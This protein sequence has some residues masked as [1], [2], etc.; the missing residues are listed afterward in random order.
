MARRRAFVLLIGNKERG[1]I[2]HFQ[3]LQEETAAS[4]GRRLGIDVEV[5]F[6]PG[7]DQLR[8]L[9]KRL[10]DSA[11][12]PLDAVLTEPA[13]T[14]TMDLVLREL[15]GKV[16]LVILSAWGPSVE[17]AAPEW[18]AG[19]PLGTVG[20]DHVRVGEIQGRQVKA[21]LPSGGRVLCVAGPLRS[22]A[23]QQRLEGLKSQVGPGIELQ[24]ISA[25][26]WTES[27]GIVAFND[28]Y[29][30]AKAR[31]PIVQVVAAGNDELA[32]GARR[33]CEALASVEHRGALLKAR[34]IGVDACPTFGQRLVAENQIAASVFTPANTGLALSHLHRFWT[35]GTTVPLRSFTEARP[36]PP[37][38]AGA[39]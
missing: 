27:D 34:F 3:L 33:A 12:A 37:G 23:A 28:W 6:A 32:L 14:S 2:N 39:S 29:R 26:Q 11:L 22:S 13:N 9:K 5:A 38:S 31:D 25:G 30:V 17:A 1:E 16:G 21:F 8:L 15:R 20:T 19:L 35:V 18:G 24:E 7:F 4:E 10:L 36:W